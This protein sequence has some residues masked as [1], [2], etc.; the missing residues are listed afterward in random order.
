MSKAQEWVDKRMALWREYDRAEVAAPEFGGFAK[1]CASPEGV[2][3]YLSRLHIDTM[4]MP[5]E[6]AIEFAKW[7]LDTF[8]EAP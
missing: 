4:S 6:R 1:V 5:P 8:G 2:D 7:I 3:L